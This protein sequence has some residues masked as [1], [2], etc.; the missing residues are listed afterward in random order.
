MPITSVECAECGYGLSPGLDGQNYAVA[1][2]GARVT[3]GEHPSSAMVQKITGLDYWSAYGAGRTGYLSQCLCLDCLETQELD[4][5][6]DRKRC[7]RCDSER[8][9]SRRGLAGA[10]C[11]KC[12]R[13][14]FVYAITA[15]T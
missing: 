6:R 14:R 12:E 4:L 2:D 15:V 5:E 3:T 8:V 13:G 10:P 7:T 1:T 9:Y 11:P